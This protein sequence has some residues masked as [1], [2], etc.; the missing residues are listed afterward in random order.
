MEEA[1]LGRAVSVGNWDRVANWDKEDWVVSWANL[2]A[3]LVRRDKRVV[4]RR[5]EL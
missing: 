2:V 1:N 4:V 5:A 3:S